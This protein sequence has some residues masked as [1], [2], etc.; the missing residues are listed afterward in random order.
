MELQDTPQRRALRG[1]QTQ[2]VGLVVDQETM[3]PVVS[4]FRTRT[5]QS[6]LNVLGKQLTWHHEGQRELNYRTCKASTI[7]HHARRPLL[8]LSLELE[9]ARTP[10]CPLRPP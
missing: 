10:I 4:A 9:A 8:G 2:M 1:G 5:I 3:I 6:V 7:C